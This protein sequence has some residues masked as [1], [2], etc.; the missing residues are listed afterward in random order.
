MKI[1]TIDPAQSAPQPSTPRLVAKRLAASWK[2]L[3][4]V[5]FGILVATTLAAG[6]PV[7]LDSLDQLAFHASLDSIPGTEL[8]IAVTN[9]NVVVAKRALQRVETLVSDATRSHVSEI[10]SGL[11]RFLIG[12]VSVVG[13]TRTPMPE[14]GGTGILASRGYFQFIAD[15]GEQANFIQGRMAGSELDPGSRGLSVEA[16]I[17]IAA[18]RR[19]GLVVGNEVELAPRLGDKVFRSSRTSSRGGFPSRIQAT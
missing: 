9:P 18:A 17:S 3:L 1:R 19:F 12:E 7:Y 11:E 2:L 16:V 4:S 5:F 8:E 15:L 13:T 10:Q 14:G 6:T